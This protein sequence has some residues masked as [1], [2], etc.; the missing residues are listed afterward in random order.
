VPA[1][2]PYTTGMLSRY[3]MG[4]R[5]SFDLT[6]NQSLGILYASENGP[7]SDDEANRIVAGGNFGWPSLM[8]SGSGS[9]LPAL[10]CW[11]PTVAPTGIAAYEA[12]QFGP[13]Y[14]NN[15]FVADFNGGTI[16]RIDMTPD[17]VSF[18]QRTAF[19]DESGP[20]YDV[21]AGPDGFLY[22]T[23]GNQ[24]RRIRRLQP[25]DPP[26]G[27]ACAVQGQ[28][29]LLGWTNAVGYLHL[30]PPGG[31]N[32]YEVRG[33]ENG[34]QSAWL[35]CAVTVPVD[36]VA[37]LACEVTGVSV[38]L[39]WSNPESYDSLLLY[40]DASLLG[41]LGGAATSYFDASPPA[42]LVTYELAGFIGTD[43]APAM[44][45]AANVVFHFVR[46]D[47]SVGGVIDIADA[48]RALDTLFGIQGPTGCPIA[49]DMNA[50]G[51]FDIA[52]PVSI[53]AYLF[54]GGPGSPACVE[55]VS[56]LGCGS[57]PHC[58]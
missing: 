38:Q 23:T 22:Y 20:V 7:G 56:S 34:N 27:L 48:V 49:C 16:W 46:G 12:A 44:S 19:H 3:C 58:P 51:L 4:L 1:D 26:L 31:T 43:S 53:L 2:N 41:L 18:Q 13:E 39:T 15:L 32:N 54:S 5:N 52:D 35:S 14:T 8:C 30:S 37:G 47:C 17:G 21:I 9:F 45:C 6:W 42:G 50:D 29:V 33:L 28:D 25:V 57:Y 55:D 11:T 24:L 10:T 36:P 40:R